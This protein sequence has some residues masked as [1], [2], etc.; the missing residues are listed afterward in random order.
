MIALILLL[1]AAIVWLAIYWEPD[2]QDPRG[3]T[4]MPA[5]GDFSLVS[6]SGP[7]ELK[8]LRGKVVVVFFGYTTCPDVCPTSLGVLSNALSGL[9][10]TEL[11]RVQGL[12]ISVDPERDTLEKLQKYGRY[13]HP[14]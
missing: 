13:F 3:K 1:V 10:D 9:R 6:A 2:Y 8:A 7:V 5:G 12:F 14:Q 4:E 11:K